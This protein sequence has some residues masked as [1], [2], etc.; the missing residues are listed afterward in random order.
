MHDIQYRTD[1]RLKNA[2]GV[3]SATSSQGKREI[4]NTTEQQDSW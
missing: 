4:K 1:M 2:A 3:N